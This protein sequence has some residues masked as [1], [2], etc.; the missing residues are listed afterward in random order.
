MQSV[1]DDIS[2]RLAVDALRGQLPEI[3]ARSDRRTLYVAESEHGR[4]EAIRR[5]DDFEILA[6][7]DD[8]STLRQSRTDA[9]AGLERRLRREGRNPREVDAALRLFDT[10]LEGERFSIGAETYVHGHVGSFNHPIDSG[11][12]GDS[13][14][15]IGQPT[16]RLP[17]PGTARQSSD[18]SLLVSKAFRFPPEAASTV[19][20][21]RRY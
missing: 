9:R 11:D 7:K 3:A 19:S 8:E 6:T 4:V 12:A 21:R 20:G 17:S 15:A 5:G 13:V 16:A 10:A 2:V 18:S 14:R 1:I